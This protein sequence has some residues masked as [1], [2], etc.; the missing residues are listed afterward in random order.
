[1]RGVESKSKKLRSGY[2]TGA[3]A[4]AAAKAAALLLLRNAKCSQ[5]SREHSQMPGAG[6]ARTE[7]RTPL[8]PPLTRGDIRE[9]EIPF[10]DGS[11]VKF[12]VHHS[13]LRTDGSDQISTASVIKDA[14]D[15]PDVTHGAEIRAEVF[16]NAEC[17]MRNADLNSRPEIIIRG[18]KGVGVM[19]KPGLAIPVGEPAINPIPRRMIRDAMM[20]AV[21]EYGSQIPHSAFRIPHLE[22][23]ISVPAGEELAKKTLNHRLGIV[24]GISILGTTGIVRPVST[25]AYTASITASMDVAKAAGVSVVVLSSGRTSEKAHMK[26]FHFPEEA[27][28]MM[29]D[30]LEFALLDAK[31]HGFTTI[32]LCAQW[33]KMIKTAMGTPQTH[34]RHGA[35]EAGKS[36]ELLSTLGIEIPRQK[37]FNTTREIYDYINSE[38]RI[39]NSAF[40][41]VCEATKRYAEGLT[42]G[43]PVVVH[44]VSYEGDIIAASE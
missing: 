1:M 32:H 21:S 30:Y 12:N 27:Y 38:F 22:V 25:E 2:T 3:C 29:G 44:L 10:P 17:G 40:E 4:A 26:K 20:E 39:P 42:S 11:R 23:T 15:D 41:P 43:I 5:N 35:L 18:G 19:T 31:A 37:T 34:V 6:G 33:A 7:G 8:G 24:G 14:G 36:V 13:E 28:V 9:V 16:M